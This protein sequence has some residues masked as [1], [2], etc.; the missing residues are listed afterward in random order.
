MITKRQFKE[1]QQ[2]SKVV[3]ASRVL[4]ECASER[5][6]AHLFRWGLLEREFHPE[7]A[8]WFAMLAELVPLWHDKNRSNISRFRGNKLRAFNQSITRTY[9]H[10]ESKFAFPLTLSNVLISPMFRNT[11]LFPIPWYFSL[12]DRISRISSRPDSSPIFASFFQQGDFVTES[13]GRGFARK[14]KGARKQR[15]PRLISLRH[16]TA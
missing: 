5:L 3:F 12:A 15:T 9:V 16:V 6:D 1:R 8:G 10:Y 7:K 2:S 13:S 11:F 4:H 14:G